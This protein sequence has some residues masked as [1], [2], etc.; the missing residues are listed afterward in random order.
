MSN[1]PMDAKDLSRVYDEVSEGSEKFREM[2]EKNAMSH[3]Q[4]EEMIGKYIN[5][6]AKYPELAAVEGMTSK[7]FAALY[8]KMAEDIR[9]AAEE[10]EAHKEQL[11][12]S[13]DEL[14]TL[15]TQISG[16]IEKYPEV[17]ESSER[18][19]MLHPKNLL[20]LVTAFKEDAAEAFGRIK[21]FSDK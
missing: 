21:G 15:F 7:E 3:E 8:K 6:D 14:S 5:A 12:M 9:S 11:G 10:F 17:W 13:P 4:I 20:M 19:Q 2:I 16:G 1:K 18:A